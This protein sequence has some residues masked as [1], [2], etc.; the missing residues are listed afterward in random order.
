MV[1]SACT[2]TSELYILSRCFV[3]SGPASGRE[4]D[5]SLLFFFFSFSFD[6]LLYFTFPLTLGARRLQ[7]LK[8]P[9]L[10]RHPQLRGKIT[11]TSSKQPPL[12]PSRSLAL[13]ISIFILKRT[14]LRIAKR[15][16]AYPATKRGSH[17]IRPAPRKINQNIGYTAM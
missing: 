7:P 14:F 13:F 9:A 10:L 16:N 3:L 8:L 2:V 15:L 1:N 17:I 6:A 4:P 5:S 11:L 12:L